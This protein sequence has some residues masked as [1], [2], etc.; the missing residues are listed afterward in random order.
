MPA[1]VEGQAFKGQTDITFEELDK[2]QGEFI[3]R[4]A[5]QFGG[6]WALD[7]PAIVIERGVHGCTGEPAPSGAKGVRFPG[8]SATCGSSRHANFSYK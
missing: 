7:S 1:G 8:R 4:N 2:L 5:H 3:Y 6:A